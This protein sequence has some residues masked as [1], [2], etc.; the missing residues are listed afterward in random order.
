MT[1]EID[2]IV[3]L[4]FVILIIFFAG[5]LLVGLISKISDFCHEL[6]YIN[7]EIARTVGGEQQYWKRKKRRLWRMLLPFGRR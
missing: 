2:P 6:D 3:F 5:L 4:L 1:P 7:R